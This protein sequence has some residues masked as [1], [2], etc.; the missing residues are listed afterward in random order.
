MS[1]I[2]TP[3]VLIKKTPDES[4]QPDALVQLRS[5]SFPS[6]AKRRALIHDGEQYTQPIKSFRE[7]CIHSEELLRDAE[8]DLHRRLPK[9]TDMVLAGWLRGAHTKDWSEHQSGLIETLAELNLGA[10]LAN[11]VVI[12][13]T[14]PQKRCDFGE[15]ARMARANPDLPHNH[16][17]ERL[18][19]AIQ[20]AGIILLGEELYDPEGL[21]PVVAAFKPHFHDLMQLLEEYQK[22]LLKDDKDYQEVNPKDDHC[23]AGAF[24]ICVLKPL[25]KRIGHLSDETADRLVAVLAADISLH[26]SEHPAASIRRLLLSKDL[27]PATDFRAP[28]ELYE[29]YKSGK[30]DR[31]TLSA[32]DWHS[33]M[34]SKQKEASKIDGYNI[35]VYGDDGL[36]TLFEARFAKHIQTAK[37]DTKRVDWRNHPIDREL[38]YRWDILF[39]TVDTYLMIIPGIDALIRKLKVL[40]YAI[41]RPL[42]R[43]DTDVA[44]LFDTKQGA[45]KRTNN[46]NHS[47]WVRT[48]RE[49]LDF[50]DLITKSPFAHDNALYRNIFT[51]TI[52]YN[53]W[54]TQRAFEELSKGNSEW[55]QGV[56]KR[57]VAEIGLKAIRKSNIPGTEMRLMESTRSN[58]GR[59]TAEISALPANL[60]VRGVI[61]ILEKI[62]PD[63]KYL[64]RFKRRCYAI[65]LELDAV[66]KTLRCKKGRENGNDV[67]ATGTIYVYSAETLK[68]LENNFQTVWSFACEQLHLDEPAQQK[69]QIDAASLTPD[70][71]A[72]IWPM[73]A[74]PGYPIGE[75][76]DAR[77]IHELPKSVREK[78]KIP[79][80]EPPF[81]IPAL[82]LE[83]EQLLFFLKLLAQ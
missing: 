78:L 40:Y 80:F 35:N 39:N 16:I 14:H 45:R 83:K 9:L 29:A 71:F 37:H 82:D 79:P 24:L 1:N 30:L 5:E 58:K 66:Q 38:V 7:Y 59:V 68:V 73:L 11:E 34:R 41:K 33:I 64:P 56:F 3:L 53:L 55:V 8:I 4:V 6:E 65:A 67:E 61:D 27:R 81:E 22:V 75:Q 57:K 26:D 52:L 17:H 12:K 77:T 63:S 28:K 42:I 72:K 15:I 54:I 13:M 32:Q 47:E 48:M 10:R 21:L 49:T 70:E 31:L 36:G 23:E 20:L 50:I 60:I 46:W 43:V 62:D 25:I 19:K 51:N 69:F 44:E 76:I 18:T 74:N 2:E